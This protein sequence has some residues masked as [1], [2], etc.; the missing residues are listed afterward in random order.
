MLMRRAALQPAS[1]AAKCAHLRHRGLERE[2]EQRGELEV[3]TGPH[4]LNTHRPGN[5]KSDHIN[6]SVLAQTAV[7]KKT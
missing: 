6:S 4:D 1:R 3:A 5:K 2:A 7:A